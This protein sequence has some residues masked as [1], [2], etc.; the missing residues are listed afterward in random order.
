[1]RNKYVACIVSCTLLNM[2]LLHSMYKWVGHMVFSITM[3]LLK[4][5]SFKGVSTMVLVDCS[6]YVRNGGACAAAGV[7]VQWCCC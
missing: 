6:S 1:M 2:S 7:D 3:F 5:R 4:G